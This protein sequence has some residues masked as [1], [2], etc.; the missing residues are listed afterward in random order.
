MD[1]ATAVHRFAVGLF[2]KSDGRAVDWPR[3][4]IALF[5]AGLACADEALAD[6]N[7]QTVL[8]R[9]H[10]AAYTRMA[11]SSDSGTPFVPP[12]IENPPLTP[13]LAPHHD[14]NR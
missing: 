13:G 8:R 4:A 14:L 12:A 11:G 2:D 6:P 1:P 7:M 9:I 3:V 10:D 5:T